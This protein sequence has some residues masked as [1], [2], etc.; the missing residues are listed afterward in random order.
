M[1]IFMYPKYAK[2]TDLVTR[3]LLTNVC[4]GAAMHVPRSGICVPSVAIKQFEEG[5]CTI[6]KPMWAAHGGLDFNGREEWDQ[7]EKLKVCQYT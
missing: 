7:W 1:R 2:F 5:D 4:L 3:H 6:E